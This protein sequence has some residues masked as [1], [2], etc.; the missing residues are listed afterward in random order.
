M[1]LT[2]E[3]IY[4]SVTHIKPGFLHEI[5]VTALV[6]D[7][8][9]TLTG[10]ESQILDSEVSEWLQCMKTSG[11]RMIILSNNHA[12]RVQP[13][14]DSVGLDWIAGAGKPRT[15]GLKEAQIRFGVAKSQMAVIGDQ[16]FTD[17][18]SASMF[19]VQCF[20]VLPRANDVNKFV[21]IKR[22]FEKPFIAN[23]FR[24]GGQIL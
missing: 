14:A 12:E 10:D 7:V 18:L 9:N 3:V 13:F 6:L 15:H 4:K 23:Y 24:K 16:I 21:I 17:R 5:N 11:I 8:D 22:F 19:G 2:P 1:W 20:M